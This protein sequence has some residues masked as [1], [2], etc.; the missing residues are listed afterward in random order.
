MAQRRPPAARIFALKRTAAD[1]EESLGA[2]AAEFLHWDFHE[3]NGL[4]SVQSVDEAVQLVHDV[5]EMFSHGGFNLHKFTSNTRKVLAKTP[6]ADHAEV[7]NLD[8]NRD[9][10]LTERAL[11]VQWSIEHDA[12]KFTI[13]SK[14]NPQQGVASFPP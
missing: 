12:F 2:A 1:N 10:D 11:G 4:K 14:N 9:T 5:K 7:K 8:F 3:D 6:E 13:A